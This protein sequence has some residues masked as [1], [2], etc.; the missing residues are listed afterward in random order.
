M[1]SVW[2]AKDPLQAMSDAKFQKPLEPATCE[3]PVK[4]HFG[5][6]HA[7]GVQGTPT[8]ILDNGELVG[9]YVPYRQ[10]AQ[11]LGAG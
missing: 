10:L 1:V 8:L 2:C 9:G 3:N 5:Q 6:G 4:E 11:M 7:L